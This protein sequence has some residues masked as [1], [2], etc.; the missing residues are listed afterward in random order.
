VVSRHRSLGPLGVSLINNCPG[1]AYTSMQCRMAP[2]DAKT[3][4][5]LPAEVPDDLPLPSN[6][7][8]ACRRIAAQ[9]KPLWKTTRSAEKS[10]ANGWPFRRTSDRPKNRWWHSPKRRYSKTSSIEVGATRIRNFGA[11]HS[12]RSWDGCCRARQVVPGRNS[13][14]RRN[15]NAVQKK[16]LVDPTWPVRTR[17]R[18]PSSTPRTDPGTLRA[19]ARTAPWRMLT[20]ADSTCG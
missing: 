3:E 17:W 2:A 12:R 7:K 1:T 13:G 6:H 19:S 5:V 9:G 10:F 11:T 16:R 14:V 8:A 15:F 20:E 4:V 18:A